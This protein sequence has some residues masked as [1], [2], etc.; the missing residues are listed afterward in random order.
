MISFLFHTILT[1][2][3]YFFF[4]NNTSQTKLIFANFID[5]IFSSKYLQ[6][7]RATEKKMSQKQISGLATTSAKVFYLFEEL[8][9][10]NIPC[11]CILNSDDELE[12]FKDNIKALN[13][14]FQADNILKT[15]IQILVFSED[16]YESIST[17][18]YLQ[19]IKSLNHLF[20][21]LTTQKT[22]SRGTIPQKAFQ[23]KRLNS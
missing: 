3:L 13:E 7:R 10:K 9:L 2:K 11:V 8:I 15:A 6:R 18:A 19:N 21:L 16:R 5:I 12:I 14:Y 22:I 1:N 20:F 23:T 4:D 17:I